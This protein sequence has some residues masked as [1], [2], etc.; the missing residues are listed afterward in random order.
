MS[1]SWEEFR[2]ILDTTFLDN[3]LWAELLA[4]LD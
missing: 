2:N 1:F 4:P 3:N